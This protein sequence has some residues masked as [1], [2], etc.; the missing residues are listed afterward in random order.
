MNKLLQLLQDKQTLKLLAGVIVLV[1]AIV[2]PKP[3][4]ITYRYGNLITESTYWDGLGGSGML[5]DAR[6]DFVKL[7]EDTQNLNICYSLKD[8]GSCI[9][10]QV[11]ENK[12]FMGFISSWF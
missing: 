2:F 7:D 12:G 6:A 11:I 10:Y 5:F 4:Q 3:Q 9:T 1:V 8:E